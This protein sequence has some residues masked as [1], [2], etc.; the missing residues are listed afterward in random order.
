MSGDD[1]SQMMLVNGKGNTDR[2]KNGGESEIH[3]FP[4]LLQAEMH[5]DAELLDV[6]DDRLLALNDVSSDF[7]YFDVFV[8][9]LLESAFPDDDVFVEEVVD[10]TVDVAERDEV[11]GAEELCDHLEQFFGQVGETDGHREISVRSL[12]EHFDDWKN[13]TMKEINSTLLLVFTIK[14][15]NKAT[16]VLLE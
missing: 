13:G 9:R 12:F 6:V 4:T 11:F 8:F 10:S 15:I 5:H 14:A 3:I 1:N 7:P 16:N 2:G